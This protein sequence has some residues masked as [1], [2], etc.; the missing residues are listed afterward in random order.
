MI[1]FMQNTDLF[2]TAQ[3]SQDHAQNTDTT[4][5]AAQ[6]EGKSQQGGRNTKNNAKKR[7]A[8]AKTSA[9]EVNT[10]PAQDSTSA[11]NTNTPSKKS[12]QQVKGGHPAK[13]TQHPA[14]HQQTEVQHFAA[15]TSTE[16]LPQVEVNYTAQVTGVQ[17]NSDRSYTISVPETIVV[18]APAAA[19]SLAEPQQ[20]RKPGRNYR[21]DTRRPSSFTNSFSS[22][23]TAEIRRLG[24]LKTILNRTETPL[25]LDTPAVKISEES[26]TDEAE[27]ILLTAETAEFAE[28]QEFTETPIE[29]IETSTEIED[30]EIVSVTEQTPAEEITE[31][32]ETSADVDIKDLSLP[33]VEEIIVTEEVAAVE[34]PARFWGPKNNTGGRTFGS[35][36]RPAVVAPVPVEEV[37]EVEV[38]VVEINAETAPIVIPS[39]RNDSAAQEN[40]AP[41]VK[42]G[43]AN[44]NGNN[45]HK[46]GRS[47][48]VTGTGTPRDTV[49]T[50]AQDYIPLPPIVTANKTIAV[51]DPAPVHSGSPFGA[52]EPA[53]ARGFGPTPR[54]VASQYFTPAT[55]RNKSDRPFAT[56]SFSQLATVI[57]DAFQ[58]NMERMM[59]EQRRNTNRSTFTIAMPSTERV[60][61]FVDVANLL[62]SARSMRISVDFGELLRFLKADRK[63]IRAQAYCP[64]SPEPYADQQFLQ[65]VKGLGYR[66]TTKDYK[67]F[68]SGAKKADLDLDLCMDIVR[69]VDSQSV[70]TIVLVSGDSDFL[71]LLEYCSDKGVRV[72]VAAFDESTAAILR[73]SCD[74]FINLS[75][76]DDIRF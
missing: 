69:M 28:T 66:I 57:T 14:E 8:Q 6:P 43:N 24:P 53:F 15:D 27:E 49:Q 71:P 59:T 30:A 73:Q 33:E 25:Q 11:Q 44:N 75:L 26:P 65:A 62:Y 72:E 4:A 45:K 63:L 17:E 68:S 36:R 54:G 37:G 10:L 32:D 31:N 64:T 21:F 58:Q 46:K 51:S 18:H 56:D 12:K 41:L 35:A 40:N 9:A 60:G 5:T 42:N 52:P 39:T 2:A 76:V 38:D 70:D 34:P 47:R 50:D 48:T 3:A 23:T 61:V 22:N 7:A 1:Q 74:V 19:E 29:I 13:K 67:T 16:K 55:P 20:E